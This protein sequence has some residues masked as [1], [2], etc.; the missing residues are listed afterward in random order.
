[1]YVFPLYTIATAFIALALFVLRSHLES[2]SH[3]WFAVLTSCFAVWTLSIALLYQQIFAEAVGRTAFAAASL[4]PAALL[5][6]AYHYP[7]PSKLTTLWMCRAAFILGSGFA[8][9]SLST[10]LVLDR[11]IIAGNLPP[12][13]GPAY[14]LFALFF[15]LA[16]AIAISEFGIRFLRAQ[17]RARAQLGYLTLG[18]LVSSIG[19]IAANLVF[20][21]LTTR[22]TYSWLGPYFGLIFIVS[23]AHGI[24]RHRLLDLRVVVHR[25]LTLSAAVLVSL[26]PVGAVVALAWPRLTLYL[27]TDELAALLVAVVLVGLLIPVVRDATGRLLD[28]YVYRT[29]ANY[30]RTVREASQMLTRVLDLKRL[31]PFLNHT[32]ISSTAAEGVAIYLRQEGRLQRQIMEARP[33]GDGFQAPETAPDCVGEALDEARDVLVTDELG[34]DPPAAARQHLHDELVRLGWALLLPLLAENTVIGVIAVGPKRSGDPFY[35]QDLDLLMTLAAQAGIAVNNAQLYA[36]V[37]LA[38][39]YIENI[40]ATIESGVVA[41]DASGRIA[42]FN[43]AAEQLTGL[44]AV[45]VR[46]QPMRTLPACLR[47]VLDATLT[48][49]RLV[50]RPEMD[51]SDGQTIRPIICTTSPLRDPGGML[52]GA[53]AVFSD[54]TPLKE[55]ELERRRAERLAYLA[56]F[57][58]G[59]AH[60]IKNPLV[61]VKTFFQLLDRQPNLDRLTDEL[62]Q[63]A[64]REVERMEKLLERLRSLARPSER[65]QQVLDLRGPLGESLETMRVLSHEKGIV[66]SVDLGPKPCPVIGDHGELV[67]LFLNL[68]LNAVEA[69]PPRGMVRAELV[70]T[71][72]QATVAVVDTG[73]GI[74]PDL[75]DRLFEPFVTTKPHGSGLGLAIC[76][77]VARSHGATLRATNR[78]SGGAVFTV[79]FPLAVSTE[80]PAPA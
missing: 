79:Q 27:E 46:Q 32:V 5:Y 67:Q 21:L 72:D 78:P 43:R 24:I 36:Q 33:G 28:R 51:L 2:P 73:P 47:E 55:L 77:S 40:V 54:L 62:G 57:A 56:V 39:E 1:M 61:A 75:L 65:P 45:Q 69:T 30:R 35:P 58:A 29:Q 18:A 22:S 13:R 76:A 50:T 80:V 20:P 70:S 4:I 41:V 37:V 15:L 60:E 3:R 49:G 74:Q 66:V 52:L 16:W 25:G 34:A 14:P 31:L 11:P 8:L 63:V 68:L 12:K 23:I 42:M 17:G 53:V 64:L 6:V 10:P 26:L 71:R 7:G 59:I 19:G 38:N 9:L 44:T 48:A